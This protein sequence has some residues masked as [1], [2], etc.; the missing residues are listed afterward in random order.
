M[1]SEVASGQVSI[2]PTFKGFRRLVTNEVE[3]SAKDASAGFGRI[4]GKGTSDI[5]TSAGRG[6]KDAFAS[7][8]KG[9]VDKT[10]RAAND[11]YIASSRQLSSARLKEQDAS[12]KVRIA[13]V[14]LAEARKK[15]GAESARSVAAEER[16]ATAQRNLGSV[17]DSV[18]GA[19]SRLTSAKTALA[20][21]TDQSN[22]SVTKAT[23]GFRS[24]FSTIGN[25]SGVQGALGLFRSLASSIGGALVSAVETASRTFLTLG[26]VIAGVAAI[27]LTKFIKDSVGNAS[28]LVEAG[29]AIGA[30]FGDATQAINDYA[31]G[32]AKSIGQSTN[33]ALDAAKTFGIFGKA[34]GLSGDELASFATGFVGLASDL[35]SFNNTSP[36]EAIEALGAG[37]RGEAEPLRKY[38][39][40]LDDATLKA[41]ATEL[42]I[43]DGTDALTQQQRVLAA[44]AEILAQAST[45]QGDF[46]RTSE[47]LANQQRIAAAQ[48]ENLS[49]SFGGIFLPAVTTV[50]KYINS[51]VLPG[52]QG[53]ADALGAS[54]AGAKLDGFAQRVTEK[55]SEPLQKVLD[56]VAALSSTE[57]GFS[58]ENIRKQFTDAFPGMEGVFL[59]LEALGPILPAL[60]D[61]FKELAPV[62]A[63]AI[64]KL[65]E[66]LVD[67]L[68]QLVPLISSLLSV[69]SDN[70]EGIGA[71]LGFIVSGLGFVAGAF[72][73]I[74]DAIY[75]NNIEIEAL[76]GTYGPVWAAITAVVTSEADLMNAKIR[77]ISGFIDQLKNNIFNFALFWAAT[78]A[79]VVAVVQLSG[80]LVG[81][82]FA[83]MVQAAQSTAGS[84]GAFVGQA[85]ATVGSLPGQ[86]GAALASA[87]SVL[88]GF[89]G[90]FFSSGYSIIS[91]FVSGIRAGIGAIGAAVSDA[92]AAAAA[93]LPH[94]PAK[95]GPFSGSGWTRVKE[96]GS[97]LMEQFAS[98]VGTGQV[99]LAAT[100]TDVLSQSAVSLGGASNGSQPRAAGGPV[101]QQTNYITPGIDPVLWTRQM[102]RETARQFAGS[103]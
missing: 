59:V 68:P 82:A 100:M 17:Q 7:S 11:E 95:K 30:V 29:T 44:H 22:V 43:Y 10:L 92:M 48:T 80:S 49:T 42:G 46:A 50:M 90:Q 13:E 83:G 41:R 1:P 102:G 61:A 103:V 65:A 3:G 23:G 28:D 4:F 34:A 35:A 31:R 40:L 45:Q 12:G 96:G 79:R 37:L 98:G 71:V 99:Q 66:L 19:S 87:A 8:T 52:F 91:S 62:L 85:A 14:A 18:R 75:G 39:I 15:T 70:A 27:G 58:F 38:G 56:I 93:M 67:V 6:F 81:G 25:S 26:A 24:F 20:A 88:A 76:L 74:S 51:T 32:A 86:I 9:L 97:A 21:A 55:L 101:L 47:G 64:P 57:G 53:L 77:G 89:A 36:E 2:T 84:F 60:A 94:S 73:I 33:A 5:G 69:I 72:Q 54:G 63:D 16:L 78:F